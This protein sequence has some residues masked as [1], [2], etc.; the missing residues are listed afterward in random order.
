MDTCAVDRNRPAFS[1]VE[2]AAAIGII[3]IL[4]VAGV[5]LLNGPGAQSRKAG[6][7]LLSGV[8]ERARAAAIT[9]RSYVV[10]AVAEPGDLPSVDERCRLGL[11]KVE[12]WPDSATEVVEGVLMSQW[13]PMGTGLA[14]IG[15]E[16]DGVANP[17]D[18][19]KLTI[20]HVAGG[21]RKIRCHA[22]AFNPR[23]GLHHPPG[24]APVVMRVAEGSYREG[25][26]TPHRRAES[27]K[28]T[29]HRLKIGRVTARPYTID[30]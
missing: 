8:I 14:L 15:G 27:G 7:D 25:T 24:S 4:S 23:G 21:L 5:S 9:S 11:F 10:L 6:V 19:Q 26:A 18:A 20:S 12:T 16:V 3:V 28:I 30:G 13:R 1:L 2:M 22:I 17:L 29:E